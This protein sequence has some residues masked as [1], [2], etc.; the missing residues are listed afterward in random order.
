MFISY[1]IFFGDFFSLFQKLYKFL[2]WH[3]EGCMNTFVVTVVNPVMYV[4]NKILDAIID[5]RSIQ[6]E[7]EFSIVG[8]L[9]SI[10]PW[11]S[12]L[13]HRYLNT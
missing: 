1:Y 3:F 10:F 9:S 7:L 11:R 12:F 2:G 5:I 8:F 6:F 4:C 13:A